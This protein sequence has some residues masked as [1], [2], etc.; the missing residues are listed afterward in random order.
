[1][2]A[3]TSVLSDVFGEH[4]RKRRVVTGV[5]TTFAFDPKF[6][7]EEVVPIL[8]D[9]TLP[10]GSEA[11]LVMLEDSVRD[12]RL[13]VYYDRQALQHQGSAKLDIRRI[14]SSRTTGCFHPKLVLL[15][16]EEEGARSL[17]VA[18]LS[19]N[20]TRSGWWQNV[21]AGHVEVIEQGS[22]CSFRADL[23]LALRL[24][25]EAAPATER[26]AEL[27][28]IHKF[29]R[30]QVPDEER[31]TRRMGPRLFVGQKSLPEFLCEALPVSPEGYNLEILSPYFDEQGAPALRALVKELKPRQ[32]R[33]FL[34]RKEDGTVRC[35]KSFFGAASELSNMSWSTLPSDLLRR[36]GE[37]GEPASRFVHAK[38]YRLWSQSEARQFILVGSANL[39]QQAHSHSNAGNL[40]ASFLIEEKVEG[41]LQWWLELPEGPAPKRFLDDVAE[42]EAE[43]DESLQE[44]V[45]PLALEFSWLTRLARVCW[46]GS[47]PSPDILLSLNGVPFHPLSALPAR[48]WVELPADIGARLREHLLSS[49]FVHA[50]KD[51]RTCIL[52]VQEEGMENKP[53]LLHNLSV[54]DILR[55]WSFFTDEQKSTF[56]EEKLRATNA[57]REPAKQGRGPEAPSLFDRFAG[58]FHAFHQFEARMTDALSHGREHEAVTRL[59]GARHDSLGTLVERLREDKAFDSIHRYV[60]F[61]TARQMLQ[62]LASSFPDFFTTNRERHRQLEALLTP[63]AQLRDTLQLG[64]TPEENAAFL[65]WFE[66]AFLARARE[67]VVA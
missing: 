59:F 16:L 41:R 8:F 34:P 61:L 28:E 49:S 47:G 38:V 33:V 56:L 18:T 17:L 10:T 45:L 23:F 64:G 1:M 52:L 44:L 14:P 60:I 42:D 48:T 65:E 3:P 30:Y 9:R 36:R 32:A 27:D 66:R 12:T 58:I 46:E 13:A 11:R 37:D 29:L 55:Y 54:E 21:E 6:F 43:E 35:R 53:S 5:F 24:I 39:T 19:A 25:R 57:A 67:E 26:H 2:S 40:E 15:L 22:P 51:G 4:V 62:T 7:E 20:L 31:R 50:S 63:L